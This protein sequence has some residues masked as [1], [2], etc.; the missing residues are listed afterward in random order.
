VPAGF[1]TTPW[2]WPW[3]YFLRCYLPW[4][5][6]VHASKKKKAERPVSEVSL[7]E[8]QEVIGDW[9]APDDG[10]MS[11]DAILARCVLE[12]LADEEKCWLELRADGYSATQAAY[13]SNIPPAT[14]W[15]RE[16]RLRKKIERL[17][18][19][20]IE[21][22]IFT[23]SSPNR[24]SGIAPK[25]AMEVPSEM[26]T[27][28]DVITRLERIEIKLDETLARLAET[29]ERVRERWPDDQRIARAVDEF[30]D[31]ALDTAA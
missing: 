17:E 20:M 3:V 6:N 5:L 26:A 12:Q 30:I 7:D 14:A 24:V 2:E 15:K 22:R 28:L 29:C 1:I 21:R 10:F 23:R 16:E 4:A 19:G 11:A 31:H 25:E 8:W 13:L 9:P 18:D 27:Q